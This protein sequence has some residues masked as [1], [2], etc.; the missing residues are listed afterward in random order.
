MLFV[1]KK[2]LHICLYLFC[3]KKMSFVA[4]INTITLD[5]SG[6]V[7]PN[8]LLLADV[9]SNKVRDKLMKFFMSTLFFSLSRVMNY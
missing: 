7:L 5:C 3:R 9:D 1:F 2:S 4:P 8:A 6:N